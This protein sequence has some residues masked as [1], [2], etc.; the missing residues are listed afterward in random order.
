MRQI[1]AEQC[2]ARMRT[3]NPWWDGTPPQIGEEY[4][5]LR[6]RAYFPLFAKLVEADVRRAVVLM[7]PRRVGKSVLMQQQIQKLLRRGIPPRSVAYISLDHPLYNNISIE[8]LTEHVRKASGLQNTYPAFLFLDEIQSLPEWE[9]HLKAFVDMHPKVKCVV[10]GSAA[11]ALRRKSV[12][13]GAGRFTDFLLPP[14]TFHEFLE[15]KNINNNLVVE[16]DGKW[17][18]NNI[19]ELNQHFINYINI[20]GYP[21][22]TLSKEV[23]KDPKRYFRSD[24]VEK[25]LLRDLPSLYGIQ[26]I[27]ELNSLFTS[28]AWNTAQ[29]V[30]LDALSRN[31]G[32]SKPTIRRYIQYLEAAFLIKTIH[33]IDYNAKRF[34]RANFFKVYL[35]SPSMHSALFS[36]VEA[37]DPNIG[38]LVET[39]IFSQWFHANMNLHYA[40]WDGGEVDIVCSNGLHPLW[41]V[42]VKWS[43]SAITS[44]QKRKPLIEFMQKHSGIDGSLTTLT[45][46][47]T[48]PLPEGGQLDYLPASL[49]C[50][51]VG[52]NLVKHK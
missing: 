17:S 26:N 46:T 38:A 20:G 23:Q 33:R 13:S 14:L 2:Q 40:R 50:Y 4:R 28:L 41:C 29:E 45:K 7:G 51:M 44:S 48:L 10:S 47:G 18:C 16:K 43:D 39:A 52:F 49:Y 1:S 3:E 25:V 19:E 15:L 12:E 42:E 31:S 35:T 34:R 6:H 32:V 27:P 36:P 21:E 22:L 8:D 37:N 24:I 11:A 30:S 5:E 9:R